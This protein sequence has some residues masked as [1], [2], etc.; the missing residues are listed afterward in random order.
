ML[1]FVLASS[2]LIFFIT[3]LILMTFC[4]LLLAVFFCFEVNEI[5]AE[6]AMSADNVTSKEVNV[7]EEGFSVHID[8]EEPCFATKKK[9]QLLVLLWVE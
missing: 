5:G 4:S 1:S 8:L 7:K 6:H 2:L 3:L 9:V